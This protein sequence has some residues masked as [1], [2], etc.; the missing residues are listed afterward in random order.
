[1]YERLLCAFSPTV[2]D[3]PPGCAVRSV[4]R[5]RTPTGTCSWLPS[6]FYTTRFYFSIFLTLFLF[7]RGRSIHAAH[8]NPCCPRMLCPCPCCRCRHIVAVAQLRPS[9]VSLL[10]CHGVMIGLRGSNF[11][12]MLTRDAAALVRFGALACVDALVNSLREA[13][14][15]SCSILIS[16]AR[17]SI[18]TLVF[19]LRSTW[20]WL[21]RL[22]RSCTRLKKTTTRCIA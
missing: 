10:R 17:D 8:F 11:F 6:A 16:R 1:M 20:F 19:A 9:H 18:F 14:R 15:L 13:V 4:R 5:C 7:Q 3:F 2:A 12:S 21:Q 22:L